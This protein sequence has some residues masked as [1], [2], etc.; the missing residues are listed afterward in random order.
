[1]SIG[2][3]SP[4]SAQSEIDLLQKEYDKRWS[5]YSDDEIRRMEE[6]GTVMYVAMIGRNYRIK[7]IKITLL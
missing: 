6:N 7:P 5:E 2:F 1:M 4:E 3:E